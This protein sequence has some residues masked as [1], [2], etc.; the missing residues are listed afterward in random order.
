MQIFHIINWN[1]AFY[2]TLYNQFPEPVKFIGMVYSFWFWN[3]YT[4]VKW[5]K[6]D[7]KF[8]LKCQEN[9]FIILAIR[10]TMEYQTVL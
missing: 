1:S 8:L 4:G 3:F 2:M 10:I 9:K 5:V 6:L 7:N